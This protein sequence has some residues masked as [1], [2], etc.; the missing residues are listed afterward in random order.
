MALSHYATSQTILLQAFAKHSIPVDAHTPETHL[1][2]ISA[3]GGHSIASHS[4]AA[5]SSASNWY[6][7]CAT[8]S[9]SPRL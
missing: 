3:G 2:C 9:L 8:A 4:G 7:Q 6:R 1:A 5:R